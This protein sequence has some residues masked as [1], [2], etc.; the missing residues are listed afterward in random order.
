MS[1]KDVDQ[2]IEKLRDQGF[3]VDG[4]GKGRRDEEVLKKVRKG[5]KH[6]LVTKNGKFVTYLPKTPSDHRSLPNCMPYL[7]R[8]GF[9]PEP[10]RAKKKTKD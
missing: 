8:A 6:H 1:S 3:E 4:K 7:K 10:K 2:L 9:K 5:K